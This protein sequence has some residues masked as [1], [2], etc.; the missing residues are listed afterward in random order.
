MLHVTLDRTRMYTKLMSHELE[1]S[2]DFWW[3]VHGI[4]LV[5]SYTKGNYNLSER[6]TCKNL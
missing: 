3:M 2:R 4:I 5:L 1:R 6:Y